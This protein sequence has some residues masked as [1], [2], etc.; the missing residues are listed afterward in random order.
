MP[1]S[2]PIPLALGRF[3]QLARRSTE[4]WQGGLRKL[5]AWID[6]PE[7]PDGEPS[8]PIGAIWVSLRTGL[9]HADVPREGEVASAQL[10]LTAFL[11]FGLKWAKH[12]EGRPAR[13]EVSDP[14]LRDAMSQALV[15]LDTQ[16]V[17]V[18]DLS[19]ITEVL[20]QFETEAG[21][22]R[23]LPGALEG[24]GVTAARLRAFADAARLFYERRPW[25][26]LANEDLL[27]IKGPEV[28]RDMAHACVMG[29]GGQEF[30]ISFFDSRRQFE[31]L[32]DGETRQL[33]K[34]ACGVTFGP[35]DDMP[36]ADVDAWEEHGL[37]VAEKGAYPVAATLYA[38]G[39]MRRPDANALNQ[40]EALLR[41]LAET[42]EDELD[43]GRWE[44]TVTTVDGPVTLMLELPFLLEAETGALPKTS[45]PG[46]LTPLE[47]AQDR[48]YDA[49]EATGRLRIKLARQALA[50]SPDCAD[51]WVILGDAAAHPDV[52]LAHYQRGVEGGARTIGPEKF[53]SLAG[54]FW[55]HVET[56]PHMRAR[57]ALANTLRNVG[58][59]EEA[60]E[61]YRELLRLNPNDN[62]GVRQMLV[63]ALLENGRNEEAGALLDAYEGDS[64]ATMP[65]ARTLWLLRTE[66]DSARTRA[67][68]NGAIRVNPYVAKYLLK[69]ESIPPDAPPYVALGSKEEGASVALG[70]LDAFDATPGALAWLRL[71]ASGAR[72]RGSGRRRAKRAR[73]R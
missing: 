4:V 58:R 62:Q 52:A 37:P 35:V 64:Q 43:H 21:D 56:R 59:D 44:R 27:L 61:Q 47:Q 18:E 13:V 5:P 17:V 2:I 55:E 22:G 60:L 32:V 51:A 29:N 49:M 45:A 34:Q 23:R 9:I 65:Y 11:E 30:G 72:G 14:A 57:F 50:I 10:A 16:V 20:R 39:T 31:R 3:K 8:R 54:E 38:D 24:E 28:S 66:G 68:L 67:S 15:G 26:H 69:P 1:L 40:I 53:A 73:P 25:E 36:F 71:H 41:V 63:P 46:P 48:A 6:D 7:H 42:T 12:L 33:P 19:S 70:L